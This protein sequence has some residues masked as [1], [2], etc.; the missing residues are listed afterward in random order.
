MGLQWWHTLPVLAEAEAEASG[1]QSS[2]PSL[3]YIVSSRHYAEKPCLKELKGQLLRALEGLERDV[4][5]YWWSWFL[6]TLL[7]LLELAKASCGCRMWLWNGMSRPQGTWLNKSSGQT[8]SPGRSGHLPCPVHPAVQG[9]ALLQSFSTDSWGPQMIALIEIRCI[10]YLM[11]R[12]RWSL[13]LT[14]SLKGPVVTKT[15]LLVQIFLGWL[16]CF[17]T[18]FFF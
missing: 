12:N 11:F 2:R 14:W 10:K 15:P 3:V 6:L 17:K 1:S 5:Q 8:H 18:D 9:T 16:V 13:V 7:G 4:V